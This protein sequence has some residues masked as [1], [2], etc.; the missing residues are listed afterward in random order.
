M[1]RLNR[2]LVGRLSVGSLWW[3]VLAGWLWVIW[4]FGES[5]LLRGGG[6]DIFRWLAR[7]GLHVVVYAVLA[8]LLALRLG[9]RRWPR[10]V[11]ICLVVAVGD[12]V[13][14]GLVPGRSF[15]IGNIGID[16]AG[17]ILGAG[18]GALATRLWGGIG[19]HG[20]CAGCPSF[21]RTRA[22]TDDAGS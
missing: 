5:Q 16:L 3:L 1:G 22:S 7:K 2:F 6:G 18:V 12:E 19:S 13:H 17:G 8:T 15:W 10:T 14:Q 20:R 11:A 4:I 9:A 21:G